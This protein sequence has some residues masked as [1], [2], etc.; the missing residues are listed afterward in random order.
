MRHQGRQTFDNARRQLNVL[1]LKQNTKEC[2]IL[3]LDADKAFDRIEWAYLFEILRRF[4]FGE[5]YLRWI[6]LLDTRSTAEIITN[7]KI[8]QPFKLCRSMGCPM[9]PLLFLFAIDRS[10]FRCQRPFSIR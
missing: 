1:F 7:N 4:G 8:S 2:A 10:H 3:S 6:T 5:G 9:S